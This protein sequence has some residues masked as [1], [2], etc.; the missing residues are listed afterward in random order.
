MKIAVAFSL[1]ASPDV[2]PKLPQLEHQWVVAARSSAILAS[3][4]AS[5]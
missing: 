2:L 3:G 1:L 5:D 4:F